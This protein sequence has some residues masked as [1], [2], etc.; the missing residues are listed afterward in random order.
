M[1]RRFALLGPEQ[2]IETA[3]GLGHYD[4]LAVSIGCR[5]PRVR[6]GDPAAR[7]C[8]RARRPCQR[9]RSIRLTLTSLP[10]LSSDPSLIRRCAKH[11]SLDRPTNGQPSGMS[12]PLRGCHAFADHRPNRTD[13]TF[14]RIPADIGQLSCF[15]GRTSVDWSG[16]PRREPAGFHR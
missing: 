1:G 11:H 8:Q 12:R 9:R 16:V 3:V 15:P 4:V 14:S 7:H 10:R 13:L 5:Q 2:L 6:R